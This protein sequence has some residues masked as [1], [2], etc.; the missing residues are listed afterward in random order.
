MLAF[1]PYLFGV[2]CLMKDDKIFKAAA[3][4]VFLIRYDTSLALLIPHNF[5]D[6]I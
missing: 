1:V 2:S 5:F 6:E 4:A 3:G